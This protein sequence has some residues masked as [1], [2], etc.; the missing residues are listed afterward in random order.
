MLYFLL[1]T[2]VLTLYI[3]VVLSLS[4]LYQFVRTI[5]C[6]PLKL[7]SP[8]FNQK[9]KTPWLKSLWFLGFIDLDRQGQI[10]LKKSKFTPL[11]ACE[12]V[13]AISQYQMKWGF[14]N[15][16][17]QC[18]LALLRSLLILGLIL[19]FSFIFNFKPV[20]FYQISRFLLFASF[21]I[22]W[23]RPWPV[24]V[25]YPTWLRTYTDSYA[26]GQG[27]AIDR[28]TVLVRS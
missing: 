25:P 8:K 14:P 18:I 5:T 16:D 2:L 3:D 13:R 19:I 7:Q 11:W 21:C 22:Y 17:Q 24:N 15:L 6:H 28:E 12:F 4:I 27:P 9:C 1:S 20:V 26:R 23:V 10:E